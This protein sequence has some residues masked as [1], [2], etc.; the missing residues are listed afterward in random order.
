MLGDVGNSY[1]QYTAIKDIGHVIKNVG[2]FF[3]IDVASIF[4][5]ALLLWH[6]CDISIYKAYAALQENFGWIF[7]VVLSAN[8]NSVS[9]Q[10][11]Y[12]YIR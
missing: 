5:C 3:F 11:Q 6:L 1:W 12:N 2:L 4:I 7:A 8:L 9:R 10:D